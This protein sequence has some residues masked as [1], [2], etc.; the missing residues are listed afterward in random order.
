MTEAAATETAAMAW[1]KKMRA[2]PFPTG[3]GGGSAPGTRY[4][5]A[6][7]ISREWEEVPLTEMNPRGG[8]VSFSAVK[9]SFT[10]SEM[11]PT[12]AYSE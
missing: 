2:L 10:F 7:E 9:V 4:L 3:I 5:E 1:V 12:F 11:M 6:P 8:T